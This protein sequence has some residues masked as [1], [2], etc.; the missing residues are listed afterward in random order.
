VEKFSNLKQYMSIY[1]KSFWKYLFLISWYAL[2]AVRASFYLRYC[3]Q[4]SLIGGWNT[5][6]KISFMCWYQ[7]QNLFLPCWKVWKP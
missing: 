7:W 3:L 6:G 2:V 1:G 5:S 4:P